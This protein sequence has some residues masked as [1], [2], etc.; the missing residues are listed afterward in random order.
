MIFI[1]TIWYHFCKNILTLLS[2]K[3]FLQLIFFIDFLRFGF[4]YRI[5]NLTNP[6]TFSEKINFLKLYHR[7]PNGAIL[8]DKVA[9]RGFVKDQIGNKYLIPLLGVYNDFSSIDFDKFPKKFVMKT[10]HGSGWNFLCVDKNSLNKKHISKNF[11]RWLSWNAFY[12]S[13]EWQYKG[14]EP[15]II[16]EEMLQYEIYD[17]KVYCFHGEPEYI[18]I[19]LNRFSKHERIIYDTNW[20]RQEFSILYPKSSMNIKKP[21]KLEEMLMISR[22]L[23]KELIF[24]RIDLYLHNDDI[25]FG[26]ITLHP[27]GGNCPVVPNSFDGKM[28]DKLNLQNI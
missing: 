11:K 4:K 23:S 13:R 9:V 21:N 15:K 18:Q 16:C 19:D 25:F 10:N 28:A 17:Y 22:K 2:D 5:L 1:R 7:N 3:V 26:E 8:A 12:L 6:K 20:N 24:S 14:I 27:E